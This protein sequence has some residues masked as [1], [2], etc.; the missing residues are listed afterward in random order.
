[1]LR[2]RLR[3]TYLTIS[4]V[5]FQTL[6]FWPSVDENSLLCQ[7][8]FLPSERPERPTPLTVHTFFFF[9]INTEC[10]V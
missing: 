3:S 4:E 5:Q 2:P 9:F 1:M 10:V 8:Q 7:T 6:L